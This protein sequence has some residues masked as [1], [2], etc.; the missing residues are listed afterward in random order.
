MK[1]GLF[2]LN[3]Q[4]V[5]KTIFLAA[6]TNVLLGVYTI[7][8]SGGFPTHADWAVMLKSTLAIVISNII[9][10]LGTNNEGK[11]FAKDTPN[12]KETK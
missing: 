9:K 2:T 10:A 6:A 4:D 1:S 5:I 8:N 3:T 11:L 12:G 7:V